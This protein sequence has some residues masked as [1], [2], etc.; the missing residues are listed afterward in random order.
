MSD[1]KSIAHHRNDENRTTF[2]L[3]VP[4][5]AGGG[6]ECERVVKSSSLS[7]AVDLLFKSLDS[8]SLGTLNIMCVTSFLTIALSSHVAVSEKK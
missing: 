8:D 4:L 6:E 5:L 7:N 2:I 3:C 1:E